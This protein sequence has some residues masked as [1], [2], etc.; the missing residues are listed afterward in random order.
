[1]KTG[2]KILLAFKYF[3]GHYHRYIFLIMAV[4]FSFAIITTMT[5]LSEGMYNSVYKAA[6]QHY[7]GQLFIM[8]FHK[9][10][11][12]LGLIDDEKEVR[13]A[14]K[15]LEKQPE[16]VVKRTL[17]YGDGVLYF[18][19]NSS[20]QRNLYGVDFDVEQE[21][22]SQLDY[23]PGSQFDFEGAKSIIISKPVADLLGV[24][25]GDDVVLKLKTK[26]GQNNT[27]TFIVKAIFYDESIF[28]YYKC[29]IDRTELNKLLDF[30]REAYSSLG[31]YFKTSEDAQNQ[32]EILYS[33]LEKSLP[34][35]PFINQK[36]DYTK[37]LNQNWQGIRYFVMTLE[38]F[39]SQVAELL[40]AIE[41]LSYFLY[42]MISLIVLVSIS[43]TYK[44]IIHE[45][46]SEIG[47]M[48]AMGLQRMD[49][50]GVLVIEAFIVFIVSLLIGGILSLLFL[51]IISF[52]TFSFIPGF[53]IF[54]TKGRLLPGFT[55]QDISSN[56]LLLV[57]I[58]FPALWIPSF[59]AS[60]LKIASINK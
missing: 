21:D 48:R 25:L 55:V 2:H 6:E 60:R 49:V 22:F 57:F 3:T 18:A 44:L 46:S 7:G 12:N 23:V 5:S 43:V 50:L 42:I 28:G 10:Y 9:Q 8:G 56:I 53:E 41:I 20:R 17:V 1:M 58:I 11:R 47:T 36:E 33:E 35:N 37:G 26:T 59:R 31:L 40:T 16:R 45:R 54:L 51:W 29:Y 39:V 27:G 24:R 38:L 15:S 32:A 52:F 4:S 13:Q 14:V 34:M 30:D 19:G